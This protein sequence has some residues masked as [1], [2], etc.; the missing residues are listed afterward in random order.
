MKVVKCD[1]NTVD[2]FQGKEKSIVIVS[3]VRNVPVGS[4][5]DASFV[6][7]YRRINV[8]MSRSQALLLIVGAKEMYDSQD[9]V[10][11]DMENGKE[12][13]PRKI[14]NN[15]IANLVMNGCFVRADSIVDIDYESD[16]LRKR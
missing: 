4:R 5:Y 8:A 6:K 16:I 10:I 7:D 15:I 12:L 1:V 14:Y 2:R 11:E 13:P 9:I 3:L